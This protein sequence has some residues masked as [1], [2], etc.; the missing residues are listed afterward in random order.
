M[1]KRISIILFSMLCSMSMLAQSSAVKKTAD[2]VFSLTTFKND[3]SIVG[4]TNGVFIDNDGT[5]ISAW[6][7]FDGADYAVVIDAKG[8][9]HQVDAIYGANE[10]YDLVRFRIADKAPAS[11]KAAATSATWC[12]T[13][14]ATVPRRQ[15]S[16]VLKP[17]WRNMPTTLL[18]HL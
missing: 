10:I 17:S 14:R 1:T 7:P 11:A 6:K 8:N 5:C 15:P 4:T 12:P 16:R 3:G 13:R 2:A 18:N 9:R